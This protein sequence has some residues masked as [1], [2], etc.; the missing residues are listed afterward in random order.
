[1]QNLIYLWFTKRFYEFRGGNN[2]YIGLSAAIASMLLIFH[3]FL[4]EKVPS[5]YD[6]FGDLISFV[7]IFLI[8]YIPSSIIIGYWH[9]RDQFRVEST[10][11]FFQTPFLVRCF[12][13]ILENETGTVDKKDLESFQKLLREL[14]GKTKT[15]DW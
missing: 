2:I 7:I 5:L 1:M 14:E 13:L 3:R 12:R 10:Y 6:V 15:P 8:A 9:Y 11:R 4:I